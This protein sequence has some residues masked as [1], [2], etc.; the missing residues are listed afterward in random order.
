[1]ISPAKGSE[2]TGGGGGCA[3][4]SCWFYISAVKTEVMRSVG[5]ASA[6]CRSRRRWSAKERS[7]EETICEGTIGTGGATRDHGFPRRPD[8][9]AAIGNVTMYF[10][11]SETTGNHFNFPPSTETWFLNEKL[12]YDRIRHPLHRMSWL[13]LLDCMA[14][15]IWQIY[16]G[17][18]YLILT[19]LNMRA[20]TTTHWRWLQ[21]LMPNHQSDVPEQPRT[22]RAP[23][24]MTAGALS[25]DSSSNM[26]MWTELRLWCWQEKAGG[27]I[28]WYS[29]YLHQ[30]G[31]WEMILTKVGGIHCMP[32][33]GDKAEEAQNLII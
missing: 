8:H 24:S 22:T 11:V 5:I 20:A 30:Q 4:C 6:F 17:Q 14:T 18:I 28:L 12:P 3:C 2:N 9:I 7:A 16:F 33:P 13:S 32:R 10:R 29:L 1:M 25:P 15:D 23:G 31:G 27:R 19:D 21:N 26:L